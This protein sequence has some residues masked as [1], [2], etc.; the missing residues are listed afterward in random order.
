VPTTIDDFINVTKIIEFFVFV[1]IA[2]NLLDAEEREYVKRLCH[3]FVYDTTTS[4]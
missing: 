4:V 2:E 3:T 1:E